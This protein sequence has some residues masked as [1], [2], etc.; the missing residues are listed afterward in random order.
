MRQRSLEDIIKVAD[1]EGALKVL[2]KSI[3]K[4]IYMKPTIVISEDGMF[5]S[6][7]MPV[8]EIANLACA[9]I[10]SAVKSVRKQYEKEKDAD[11][12]DKELFDCLNLSFSKCLENTFP[13]Y[14]LHPEIT[15]EILQ[16]ENELVAAR[17]AAQKE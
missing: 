12:I 2:I 7:P 11:K 3:T 5:S 6:E 1:K 14:E 4:E 16:K 9:A 15:E 8:T 10:T 17:A 13:E